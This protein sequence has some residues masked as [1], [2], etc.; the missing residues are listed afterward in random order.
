MHKD[1][2]SGPEALPDF[3]EQGKKGIYFR[4][5]NAKFLGGHRQYLGTGNIRK[6]IFDFWE[7]GSREQE[8]G[9]A[10]VRM[11][12]KH[13]SPQFYLKKSCYVCFSLQVHSISIILAHIR[14][15]SNKF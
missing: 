8:P 9:R 7:A 4:G 12:Q 2:S 14:V 13:C 6:H 10:L 3:G 11:N 15:S 1:R 5:T